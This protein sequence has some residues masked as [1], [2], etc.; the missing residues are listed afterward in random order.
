MAG[1]YL[2][3]GAGSSSATFTGG[4][5]TSPISG[6]NGSA[7]TPTYGFTAAPGYGWYY[8]SVNSTL[9]ASVNGVETVQ[10][11]TVNSTPNLHIGTTSTTNLSALTF[12]VRGGATQVALGFFGSTMVCYSADGTSGYRQ[13]G[14]AQFFTGSAGTAASPAYVSTTSY[15]TGLYFPGTNQVGISTNGI[16]ALTFDASQNATFAQGGLTLIGSYA[17]FTLGAKFFG[18]TF[19]N[20]NN[21]TGYLTFG[22]ESTSPAT[23]RVGVGR[24]QLQDF[25]TGTKPSQILMGNLEVSKTAN[26]TVVFADL[27]VHFDTT[28]A[29]GSVAFT[30]PTPQVGFRAWFTATAAQT[31]TVVTPSGAI[32]APGSLVGATRTVS[33]G[34][35]AAQYTSFCVECKDGTNYVVT[36]L[37]GTMT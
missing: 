11:G 33:A 7:A 32:F 2:F 5:I 27:D 34:V 6:A 3:L 17:N 24:T 29:A 19:I 30:M 12:G 9:A 13:F 16:A 26:Y 35:A 1:Q 10:I 36:S 14:A 18:A 31:M 15:T 20:Y 4:T 8:D 28:G 22:T 37:T 23:A 21:S 25:G